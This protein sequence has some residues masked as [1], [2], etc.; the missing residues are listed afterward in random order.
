[1]RIN[2]RKIPATKPRCELVQSGDNRHYKTIVSRAEARCDE[3]IEEMIQFGTL[4][5]KRLTRLHTCLEWIPYRGG[6]LRFSTPIR[7]AGESRALAVDHA[8]RLFVG[9]SK[10]MSSM[11]L[12]VQLDGAE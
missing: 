12:M 7:C 9:M 6:D 2:G 4:R 5:I 11:P 10:T 3:R 1:M 8:Y